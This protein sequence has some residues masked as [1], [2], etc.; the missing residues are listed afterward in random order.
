[1]EKSNNELI[2]SL[3]H[4]IGALFSVAGLVLLIIFSSLYGSDPK[5]VGFSIFGSGL[6]LLYAASALYHFISKEHRAKAVFKTID[7]SMIYV[8]IAST[9]TPLMLAIPQRGWGWSLFGIAWGLAFAG[10]LYRIFSKAERD[11]FSPTLFIIMGWL[12]ALALPVLLQSIPWSGL[13]WLIAGGILYTAGV[14]F[15][16]LEKKFPRTGWFGMHEIFHLFVMGGSLAHFWFMFKYV[17]YV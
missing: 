16:A 3:T 8:L 13:S 9:Y 12:A 7:Y 11:W 17:L 5:I 6:V 1:M 10:I 4:F 14:V 2:S 15:F